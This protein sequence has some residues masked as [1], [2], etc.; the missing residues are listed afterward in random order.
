[1]D[2]N[3][4]RSLGPE[5]VKYRKDGFGPK[6]TIKRNRREVSFSPQSNKGIDRKLNT[7][8]KCY[9]SHSHSHSHSQNDRKGKEKLFPG[10][11][12][13]TTF[14]PKMENRKIANVK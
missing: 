10:E 4:K 9:L 11:E 13:K 3:R 14:E 5:V 12:K 7:A 1:M 2:D 6:S 8:P